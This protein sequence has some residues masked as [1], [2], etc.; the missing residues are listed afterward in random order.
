M[1]VSMSTV[2]NVLPSF[3]S[4]C[5]GVMGKG[6]GKS[7]SMRAFLPQSHRGFVDVSQFS[8][9]SSSVDEPRIDDTGHFF[10]QKLP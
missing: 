1:V 4:G 10:A 3:S 5:V 7:K 6:K 2:C 8:H 9:A